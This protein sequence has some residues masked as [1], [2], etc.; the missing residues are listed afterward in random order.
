MLHPLEYDIV[1][2]NFA[3]NHRKRLSKIRKSAVLPMGYNV[4]QK[5]DIYLKRTVIENNVSGFT[6][7]L[8][9]AA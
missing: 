8:W 5:L 6:A 2:N 7:T 4:V 3:H 9:H 1:H